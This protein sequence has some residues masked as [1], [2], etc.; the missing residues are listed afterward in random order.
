MR[1]FIKDLT[2]VND[3]INAAIEDRN[4]LISDSSEKIL[5]SVR[6]MMDWRKEDISHCNIHWHD[7]EDGVMIEIEI[8]KDVGARYVFKIKNGKLYLKFRE[9]Y[10]MHC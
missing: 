1:N 3:R 2:V 7:F 9:D 5:T 4:K 6:K 10:S 8:K